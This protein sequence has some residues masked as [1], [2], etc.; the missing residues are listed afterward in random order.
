MK[1]DLMYFIGDSFT[2]AEGMGEDTKKEVTVETRWSKQ[3]SD[4]FDLKHINMAEGGTGLK[5]CYHKLIEDI[6]LFKKTKKIPFVVVVYPM[7]LRMIETYSNKHGL[8]G[9]ILAAD[10]LY[11]DEFIEIFI[12]DFVNEKYLYTNQIATILS[13]QNYLKQND[14]DFVD[15]PMENLDICCESLP[16]LKNYPDLN[17]RMLDT[18]NMIMP[19]I[20]SQIEPN[21]F[22]MSN[23]HLGHWNLKGNQI[24]A[25]LLIDKISERYGD[26][27]N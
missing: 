17:F 8:I 7:F 18:S 9:N 27:F 26:N 22:I 3:V 10:N 15:A 23:G 20:S 4:H 21:C 12:R 16:M 24:A 19:A 5:R 14:I 25:K 1:Y 11:N 2:K 6:E 13:I